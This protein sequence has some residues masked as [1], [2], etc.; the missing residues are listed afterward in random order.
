MK[1]GLVSDT[2]GRFDPALPLLFSRCDLL[3]HAGDVVGREILTMLDAVAP[4]TAVRG[5]NDLGHHGA[6]LP[7]VAVLRLEGLKAVVLHILGSPERPAPAARRAI[8]RERP[9][10]VIYGHTHKPAVELV[11]GVLFVNPGSAGTRRFD[12]PRT[13]A[14]LSVEE[15]RVRVELFDLDRPGPAVMGEPFVA[16]L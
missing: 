12:Y 7:E 8:E 3:V 14:I 4:L 15:R 11:G 9:E 5:N 6:G 1:V 16:T 2:H 10:L 13:A